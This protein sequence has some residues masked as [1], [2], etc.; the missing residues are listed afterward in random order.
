MMMSRIKIELFQRINMCIFTLNI[1]QFSIKLEQTDLGKKIQVD[2]RIKINQ[3]LNLNLNLSLN[4]SLNLKIQR[5]IKTKIKDEINFISILNIFCI[6][7]LSQNKP[8][9]LFQ[10]PLNVA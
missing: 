1:C 9:L 7:Q 6:N 10:I 2:L 5:K 8:Y 4:Q 3:S